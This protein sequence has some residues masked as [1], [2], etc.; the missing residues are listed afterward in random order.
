MYSRLRAV[1]LKQ[2]N[3]ILKHG[4]KPPPKSLRVFRPAPAKFNM[5]LSSKLIKGGRARHPQPISG[6]GDDKARF[7]GWDPD[8]VVVISLIMR[9][10][11]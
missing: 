11:I 7:R 3:E 5:S 4:A 2:E 9:P 8:K 10:L 1:P 6:A